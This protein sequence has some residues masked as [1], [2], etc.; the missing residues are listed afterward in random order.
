MTF[1]TLPDTTFMGLNLI[2][3]LQEGESSIYNLIHKLILGFQLSR[4]N[5]ST[6]PIYSLH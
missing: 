3:F 2:V 6:C 4:R 1:S 5:C